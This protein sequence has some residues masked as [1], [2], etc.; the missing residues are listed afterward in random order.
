MRVFEKQAPTI[1]RF[2]KSWTQE[3]KSTCTQVGDGSDI[4]V[5]Q[6]RSTAPVG[7]RTR[8]LGLWLT[9]LGLAHGVKS[10][11]DKVRNWHSWSVNLVTL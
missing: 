8:G 9:T 2:C 11:T 3:A 1:T 7:E 4:L 5:A 6:V 10:S